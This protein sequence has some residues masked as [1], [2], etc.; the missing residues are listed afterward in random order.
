MFITKE[1]NNNIFLLIKYTQIFRKLEYSDIYN[2][3]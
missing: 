1:C 3:P 2:M